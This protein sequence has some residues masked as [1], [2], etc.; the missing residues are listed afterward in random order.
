MDQVNEATA[1]LLNRG[2]QSLADGSLSAAR[3]EFAHVL[4]LLDG[5]PDP[6]TKAIAFYNLGVVENLAGNAELAD[7]WFSQAVSEARRIDFGLIQGLVDQVS[8]DE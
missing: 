5:A 6:V 1:E 8:D 4:E 3:S 7:G 2:V